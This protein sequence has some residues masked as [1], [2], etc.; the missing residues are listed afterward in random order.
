MCRLV[1]QATNFKIFAPRTPKATRRFTKIDATHTETALASTK[2]FVCRTREGVHEYDHVASGCS[3][4]TSFVPCAATNRHPATRT[5]PQ[6]C[7][8]LR[9]LVI[10]LHRLYCAYGVDPNASS[11]RSTSRRLYFSNAMR[12][13]YPS[14]GRIDYTSPSLCTATTRHPVAQATSTSPCVAST[15]LPAAAAL[16]QLR[17][18][19]GC[20]GSSRGSL[21]T[22]SRTPRVRVPRHV[23]RLVVDY[24]DYAA[25]SG[26]SARHA[27]RHVARRSA[28]RRLLRLRRV[29]RYIAWLVVDYF[30]YAACLGA[31]AR[32]AARHAARRAAHRRLLRQRRASGCLGTSRGSSRS[33]SCRS[34]STTLPRA[35]SSSTTLPRAGSSS[36]ISPPPRVWVPRHVA[37]LVTRLVAPLVVDYSASRG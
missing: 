3:N 8:A 30:A 4:A 2:V 6:P 26:A 27:A 31:S 14:P 16:P 5:L 18:A 34:S 20:L 19:S 9:L 21:S 28:R 24:F 32:R 25:C 23:V 37:R 13:D 12:R 36:T 11:R 15:C 17:R 29:P 7:R 1:S 10:R 35:G 22:T 33:S